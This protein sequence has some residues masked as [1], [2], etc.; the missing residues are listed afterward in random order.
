[1]EG[2]AAHWLLEQCLTSTANPIDF[3][4]RTIVVRQDH[5]ELRAGGDLHVG[6]RPECT[7]SR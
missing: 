7:L 4:G 2:T 6:H 1:M 3:L 5:I